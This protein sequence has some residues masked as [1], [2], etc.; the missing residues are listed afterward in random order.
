MSMKPKRKEAMDQA[1]EE[2]SERII[3]PAT[4]S[5]AEAISDYR[6]DNR[7]ESKADAIRRLIEAGLKVEK[8]KGKS[9]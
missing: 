9:K 2:L 5:M 8:T 7:I 6:F 3:F 1:T 4:K